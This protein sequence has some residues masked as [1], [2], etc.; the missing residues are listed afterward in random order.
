MK[1]NYWEKMAP[2]YQEEIFDVL[3][4][5]KKKWIAKAIR[6][7]ANPRHQVIEM[8]TC[9]IPLVQEGGCPRYFQEQFENS[10][11]TISKSD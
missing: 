5:D 4:N 3:Q 11:I 10:S 9:T 8:V 7:Y 1:R 6:N 2:H